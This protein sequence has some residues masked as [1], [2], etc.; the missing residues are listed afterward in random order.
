MGSM[1]YSQQHLNET[2]TIAAKLSS[3]EIERIADL[4]VKSERAVAGCFFWA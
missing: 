4:L 1:S 2:S 3:D